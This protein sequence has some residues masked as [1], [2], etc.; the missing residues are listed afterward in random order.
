MNKQK[1][2][3]RRN[4]LTYM[5]A[6]SALM[7]SSAWS[8]PV[9]SLAVT[10][11][12]A[13]TLTQTKKD[14]HAPVDLEIVLRADF[15]EVQLFPGQLTKVLR[16]R[17]DVIKG[18]NGAV[19]H[20]DG[21][22]LGPTIKVKKDQRIRIHFQNRIH[23]KSIVHWHGLHVPE[24]MDGQPRYAVG[25]ESTYTYEFTVKNHAGTYW[26]HPH[27]HGMTGPQT[28]FGLAGLFIVSDDAA[29]TVGLPTGERD[30]PLVIQDRVFD[31]S[32]QLLYLTGG[33]MDR[34]TGFHGNQILINGKAA[35]ETVV[36]PDS[37][38]L[39]V[40]NGSNARIYKLAWDDGTPLT[41][42]AT[43]GGLLERPQNRPYLMLA[44]GERVDLWVDFSNLR[45][46]SVRNLVSLPLQDSLFSG[47]MGRM[48]HGRGMMGQD[49]GPGAIYYNDTLH[50]MSFKGGGEKGIQSH[51][52]EHL[53]PLRRLE[54]ADAVNRKNP[55]Q[56]TFSMNGMAPLINNRTYEMNAV[57]PHEVVQLNT[58][59][60]W[61][62]TGGNSGMMGMMGMPH[63]VHIHGLQ[64]HIVDR[65]VDREY[66][67]AYETVK[68]GWVDSGLKDTVLLM[69]GM[70][71][72][73][74]MRFEDYPGMFLYHCHNLEHEDAGMMR[75]YLI[76]G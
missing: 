74:L 13:D 70:R 55:R 43:D 52:P 29:S 28:Y 6:G 44:P 62:L 67:E 37:H 51:P 71:V 72:K 45:K 31:N 48:R 38:R 17:A 64:F 26:Y 8:R 22:Y 56:F 15:D 33:M 9:S 32:N 25:P 57:A 18:D 36:T 73:L 59:E 69:P 3:T 23:E 61:E 76:R 39:R 41:I 63:P 60:M 20:I 11:P 46:K 19:Q 68:D 40:L 24:M 1:T 12:Q 53:L 10:L 14:N 7:L 58:T 30:I 49:A 75:N 4:F 50:I 47:H 54:N 5:A 65:D 16:Y 35:Y 27:P 42:V 34:M 66:R 21:S 2:M